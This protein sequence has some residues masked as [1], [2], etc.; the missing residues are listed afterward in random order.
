MLLIAVPTALLSRTLDIRLLGTFLFRR[1]LV[2]PTEVV[3]AVRALL[4][5][6]APDS[7]AALDDDGLVGLAREVD[8][9]LIFRET[10]H[11]MFAMLAAQAA[12][13]GP[14]PGGFSWRDMTR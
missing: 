7:V 12:V 5:L 8:H 13:Q 2:F 14:S 3:P 6:P 10:M 4:A 11:A 9:H 1:P